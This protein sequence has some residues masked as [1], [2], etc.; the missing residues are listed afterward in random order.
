MT[1]F[2]LLENACIELMKRSFTI[3]GQEGNQLAHHFVYN[4]ML[5][6][7]FVCTCMYVFVGMCSCAPVKHLPPVLVKF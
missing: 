5:W 4:R 1:V 2:H 7:K 3:K 6:S